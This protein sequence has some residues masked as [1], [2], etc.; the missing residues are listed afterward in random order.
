[1]SVQIQPA[2]LR[3]EMARRGLSV[4][5]LACA[6]KI[7]HPTVSAALAGRAISSQS[8]QLIAVALTR[9]PVIEIIDSL[10]ASGQD[11]KE[12]TQ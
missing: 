10:L 9:L 7:S 4:T 3:F 8:L 5:D 1:V 11:R 2:R 6:A 12:L